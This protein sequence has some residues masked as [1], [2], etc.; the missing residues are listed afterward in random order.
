MALATSCPS[1]CCALRYELQVQVPATRSPN[2]GSWRYQTHLLLQLLLLGSYFECHHVRGITA[3]DRLVA[4]NRV[5][6][7]MT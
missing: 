2:A 4:E 3:G 7:I 5:R 6:L 1:L